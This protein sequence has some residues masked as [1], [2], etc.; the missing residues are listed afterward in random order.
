MD[1]DVTSPDKRFR[2]SDRDRFQVEQH[3]PIDRGL[4]EREHVPVK[5]RLQFPVDDIGESSAAQHRL[6]QKTTF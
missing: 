5:Q 3:S 2:Q 4:Y 1:G 6:G